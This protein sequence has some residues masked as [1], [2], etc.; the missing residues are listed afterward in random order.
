MRALWTHARRLPAGTAGRPDS[1]SQEDGATTQVGLHSDG[2]IIFGCH[3]AAALYS[4]T[5]SCKRHG[6]DPFAYLRHVLRRRA[7]PPHA[8]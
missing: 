6:I 2:C 7:E 3:T 5:A 4:M 1:G 8:Y